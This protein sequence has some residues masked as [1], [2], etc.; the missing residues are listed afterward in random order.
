SGGELERVGRLTQP[1]FREAQA[2]GVVEEDA[3]LLAGPDGEGAEQ[4]RP[5][6]LEEQAARPARARDQGALLRRLRGVGLVVGTQR[7]EDGAVEFVE[8]GK[9][10]DGIHT[11]FG[12]LR[13]RGERRGPGDSPPG[14]PSLY[15]PGPPG[16][17][18]VPG[19]VTRRGPGAAPRTG[20]CRRRWR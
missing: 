5:L 16:G 3:V 17:A 9:G 10:G 6:D 14:P 1:R 2:G 19:V 13:N 11:G 20:R 4:A 15:R 12:H 18:E 8:R 7:E